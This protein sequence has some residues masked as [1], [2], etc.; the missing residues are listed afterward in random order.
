MIK[1]LFFNLSLIV[2]LFIVNAGKVLGLDLHGPC[3]S[4]E[5]ET[6]LGCIPITTEGF[7]GQLIQIVF[8]IAGG[9][10]FVL[11]AY[12][13]IMLSTSSGDEK[14]VQGAKEIIT[15]ALI[16]LLVALFALFLYK[17]IAVD[18]LQIP[19]MS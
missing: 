7:V 19:G 5:I 16:G 13:F 10:A 9:V 6:A 1:K 12:G 3:A 15:S 17:L 2:F 11:M 14:K 8:G 4:N 18:I